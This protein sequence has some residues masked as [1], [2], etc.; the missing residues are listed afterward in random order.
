MATRDQQQPLLGNGD[1]EVGET[2]A[3]VDEYVTNGH[4]QLR[5]AAD[6]EVVP[7]ER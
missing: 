2:T 6:G 7:V 3:L 4:G 5:E 1:E